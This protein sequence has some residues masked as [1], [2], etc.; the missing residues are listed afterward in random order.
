MNKTGRE[1]LY[2]CS[3]PDY[4]RSAGIKVN[5]S[6]IAQHCNIWRMYNDIQDSWDSVTD[7]ADWVAENQ[8]VLVAA[9]GPGHFNDP[10]MLIIGNFALS[11]EQ[12]K[13]QFGLWSVMAAPL[14]MGNDLRELAPEMKAI[15]QNAEVI[16]V[17]Q[18]VLGIQGQ[19]IHS[20]QGG[21]KSCDTWM[22]PLANGDLAVLL[23]NRCSWGLH[24]EMQVDWATLGL[25]PAQQMAVRD[26]Y[27][28]KDMGSFT[29]S[30]SQFVNVDGVAMLRMSKTQS[31]PSPVEM[32]P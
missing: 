10:D 8:Q 30:Y 5:Y 14:L 17:N 2:S 7:I 27:A 9:A 22:K 19:R 25:P 11:E 3:W 26:L 23:W 21:P 29:G 12:A 15:L 1:M 13:A 4:I 18:D 16:A 6:K 32:K 28:K 20:V 31:S 24:Q